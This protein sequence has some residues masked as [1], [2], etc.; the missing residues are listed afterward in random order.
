MSELVQD[1]LGHFLRMLEETKGEPVQTSTLFNVP[2][3]NAIWR[4][5]TGQRF[6]AGDPRL[7][8]TIE[9]SR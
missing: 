8:R 3:V 6:E 9:V 7:D 5:L 2:I 4:V 1:E